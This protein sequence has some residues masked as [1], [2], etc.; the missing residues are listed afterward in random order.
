MQGGIAEEREVALF[1]V[2]ICLPKVSHVVELVG[3]N[4]ALVIVDGF[5]ASSG[6]LA[7]RSG[8]CC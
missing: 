1:P 5:W 8:G 7:G 4:L 2:H 6:R 3:D